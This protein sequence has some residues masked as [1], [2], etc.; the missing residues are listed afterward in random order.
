MF[1]NV[2][3]SMNILNG[4]SC[5]ANPA[6][7]YEYIFLCRVEVCE[8]NWES[9]FWEI[10]Y[11]YVVVFLFYFSGERKSERKKKEN[12]FERNEILDLLRNK[13]GGNDYVIFG[14]LQSSRT[15]IRHT[16]S[17][18]W[19]KKKYPFYLMK[20][21]MH[22]STDESQA[23]RSFPRKAPGSRTFQTKHSCLRL[24]G[25]DRKN[26]DGVAR[27][28]HVFSHLFNSP[29]LFFVGSKRKNLL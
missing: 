18:V 27:E 4:F 26:V 25:A 17:R 12:V 8:N 11:I 6:S 1:E 21:T 5:F 15:Q 13:K 22:N 20:S 9:S 14:L 10:I 7:E 2:C 23:R 19:W 24:F 3:V 28:S 16:F 29:S